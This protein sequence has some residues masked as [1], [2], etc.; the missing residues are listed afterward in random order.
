MCLCLL[1]SISVSEESFIVICFHD[2]SAIRI[3]HNG[4]KDT[5]VAA[6]TEK[7]FQRWLEKLQLASIMQVNNSTLRQSKLILDQFEQICK[8]PTNCRNL[9]LRARRV[10]FNFK[11]VSLRTRRVISLY[12]LYSDSALLVLNAMEYL[13]TAIMPFWLSTEKKNLCCT[14]TVRAPV[15]IVR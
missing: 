1:V 3:S 9:H 12:T 6:G 5:L 8:R 11:D 13:W 15:W 10:L 2:N 7:D 4:L 14:V